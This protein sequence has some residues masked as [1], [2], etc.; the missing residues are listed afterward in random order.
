MIK[1]IIVLLFII[2]FVVKVILESKKGSNY[3]GNLT[4]T[5][6]FILAAGANTAQ[7][8]DCGCVDIGGNPADAWAKKHMRKLLKSGWNI[9]NTEDLKETI[10]WLFNEGHNKECMEVYNEYKVNPESVKN[11]KMKDLVFSKISESYEKQGILAWDLCRICNVA[12]WGFLAEYITYEEA[13]EISVQA[14][15]LLQEN[16]SSWDDMMES[17]FLGLL[18]W[19][20]EF[21]VTKNRR[22]CYEASKKN[23][24]SIYNV[25]WDTVLSHDDVIPPRTK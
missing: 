9:R 6:R 14:C 11:K 15:K 2:G 17:Y 10:S 25:P 1:L 12:G 3:K 8:S 23:K 22:D 21:S 7:A 5:M 18:Y 20:N 16:Y 19:N 24:D 4:P 13:I